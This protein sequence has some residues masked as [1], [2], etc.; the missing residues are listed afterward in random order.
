MNTLTPKQHTG[1]M[2][3]TTTLSGIPHPTDTA[4]FLC[5]YSGHA[6]CNGGSIG[7]N[8]IPSGNTTSRLNAVVEARHPSSCSSAHNIPSNFLTRAADNGSLCLHL[9]KTGVGFGDPN[10]SKAHPRPYTYD[11]AFFMPVTDRSAMAVCVGNSSELPG[12][13]D[14]GS[15]T[16]RASS[17]DFGES[18]DDV[19]STLS[20]DKTMPNIQVAPATTFSFQS[21]VIRIITDGEHPLFVAKDVAQ[22]L[23]YADTVNA[24][25]QFCR[26]VVKHHPIVDSLGRTQEVRVI[27]EPD[28]YRL[29]FGSKLDS[30][31]KFQDWVFEEVLP[32]IRKTGKYESKARAPKTRKV[33]AGGLTLEQQESIKAL[34][35]E[36]VKS[37]PE[38]LQAKAAI[39]L[40]SAIKSK[41]GVTYKAVP[42]EHFPEILSLM[43]RVIQDITPPAIEHKP[44]HIE[45]LDF[46]TRR[47]A[48]YH[49]T[50]TGGK[51]YRQRI[52]YGSDAGDRYSPSYH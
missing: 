47:D 7:G 29:I 50:V 19:F 21:Q 14:L 11:G 43:G 24:I 4:V 3:R 37:V 28:V 17:P 44:D 25:K 12:T 16:P 36:L 27:E 5:P 9:K 22:A 51:V 39:T 13:F 49:I 18:C 42:P 20:K 45:T 26:G 2:N 1:R 15:P 30:A 10:Q 8:T 33:L 40:W 46:D 52:M 6:N 31:Q 35:R 32:A 48:Y 38:A 34:H 23:G 41:F